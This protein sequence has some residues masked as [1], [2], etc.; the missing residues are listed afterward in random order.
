MIRRRRPRPG[1]PA[2][3]ACLWLL[4]L[5]GCAV[6]PPLP[7][8]AAGFALE[9]RVAVRYGD[10]SL[11]GR[12]TWSHQAA[13]D[14]IALASPLGNQLARIER[15]SSGVRLTDSRQQVFVAADAESLTEQQLGWRLPLTGLSGWVRGEAGAA[16]GA[17][18]DQ[19][20]RLAQLT[21]AGWRIDF[22]YDDAAARLPRRL[23]LVFEGGTRPLE[24]RLVVD[25]W[26]D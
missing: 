4:A 2:W 21:E 18:R 3:L 11:S 5:A 23:V 14:D 12:I 20:G 17:Q 24:I 15:D 8:P 9:G 22:S 25:Q 6:N 16:P 10:E 7:A 13:R 1:W 19:Q 26:A